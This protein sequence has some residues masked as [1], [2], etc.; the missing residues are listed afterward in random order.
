MVNIFQYLYDNKGKQIPFLYKLI[1]NLPINEDDLIVNDNLYLMNTNI[2]SLPDNLTIEGNF[3]ISFSNIKKLPNNLKV[4]CVLFMIFS[5][6]G[7]LPDDLIV[8][9]GLYCRESVLANNIKNDPSLLEKYKK[10]IKG[11]IYYL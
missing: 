10:Q 8:E 4:K 9:G 2:T 11:H 6:I 3:S 1:N 5:E 7:D